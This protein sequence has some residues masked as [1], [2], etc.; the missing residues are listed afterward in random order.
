MRNEHSPRPSVRNRV[1][2]CRK[3][4][5]FQ[6]LS[7]VNAPSQPSLSS[8]PAP[9]AACSSGSAGTRRRPQTRCASSSSRSIPTVSAATPAMTAPAWG[10]SRSRKTSRSWTTASR[11]CKRSITNRS[12][13]ACSCA[14]R[15]RASRRTSSPSTSPRHSRRARAHSRT[16]IPRTACSKQPSRATDP[17]P[18]PTT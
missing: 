11:S 3:E 5:F 2:R 15:S 14:V 6:C 18:A 8:S 17:R 9:R 10:R 16:R 7:I 13:S 1:P 12:M 4:P